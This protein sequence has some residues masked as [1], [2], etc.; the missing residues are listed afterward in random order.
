MGTIQ[1]QFSIGSQV[2]IR[3]HPITFKAHPALVVDYD[4]DNIVV[5]FPSHE[6][7]EVRFIIRPE[8][9]ILIDSQVRATRAAGYLQSAITEI[10]HIGS[11]PKLK[12]IIDDMNTAFDRLQ[13]VPELPEDIHYGE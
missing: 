7:H 3:H 8:D 1:D 10:K 4:R 2:S 12:T 11:S 5:T 6:F 9:A 13:T